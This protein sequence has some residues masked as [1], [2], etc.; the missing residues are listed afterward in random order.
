MGLHI[1][2]ARVPAMAQELARRARPKPATPA[3]SNQSTKP[4][5]AS[6]TRVV[7]R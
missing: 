6:H 1:K 3:Y 5:L 4:S 2:E 7:S